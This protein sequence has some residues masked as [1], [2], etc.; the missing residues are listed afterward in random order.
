MRVTESHILRKIKSEAIIFCAVYFKECIRL[1]NISTTK[2]QCNVLGFV[3]LLNLYYDI[4]MT[5]T[6]IYQT[7]SSENLPVITDSRKIVPGCFFVALKGENFDGNNFAEQAIAEG[8]KYALVSDPKF[9]DI[10][11]MIVVDD[12]LQTLQELAKLHRETFSIPVIAIG[13]SNGKTTTKELTAA[14]LQK[15]YKT[16][17]TAGNLN[18]HIGVPMTLLA[19]PRDTEITVIEIGANHAGEHAELM[20]IVQP[21]VVLVTNHGKDH[22]EGF[23]DITGVRKA[24]NEIYDWAKQNGAEI[25]VN[26]N[27]SELVEDSADGDCVLYPMQSYKSLSKVFAT[28]LYGDTVIESQLFGSF[29]EVNMLAAIALGE[30]YRV[31]MNDI[32]QAIAEY[33]PEL[34]RSQVLAYDNYE[35]VLD[36]YNANPSSMELAIADMYR[37][38]PEKKKFFILGDMFELGETSTELH[39]EL[40]QFIQ[41]KQ[42]SSD[43]IVCVGDRMN[44]WK[45][46]FP[47]HFM[48]TIDEVKSFLE[49]QDKTD[50]VIFIKGSR[51]MKSEGVLE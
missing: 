49:E 30:E 15:K 12:T 20:N 34:K 24:N 40:L 19:M 26:K 8:A 31:P 9:S 42:E 35:V 41:N 29:N 28:V 48:N 27:I 7:I 22:L 33:V 16:H 4:A 11:N 36:C 6:E 17:V 2:T 50:S 14:V 51:G 5:I 32:V 1:Y 45:N 47:F 10:S 38:Y 21:T 23:G 18:N 13:G 44:E 3:L 25:F 43:V 46:D 39:R 37:A